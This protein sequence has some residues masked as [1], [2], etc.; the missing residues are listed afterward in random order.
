MARKL[1]CGEPFSFPAHSPRHVS[2]F[3]ADRIDRE[4]TRINETADRGVRDI[5]EARQKQ[6]GALP[7]TEELLRGLEEGTKSERAQSATFDSVN[8]G[9][10]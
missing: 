6:L 5:L 4:I 9:R 10:S 2:E 8:G 7:T 1:I 3:A